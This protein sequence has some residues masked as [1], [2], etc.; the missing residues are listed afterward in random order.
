MSVI[1]LSKILEKHK[2]GWLAL[3]PDNKRLIATGDTL[4]EAL[5]NARKKGVKDPS[6]LKASPQT[7]LF[8]G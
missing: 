5:E 7:N 6:L 1:D 4:D 2:E 8:V 3:T